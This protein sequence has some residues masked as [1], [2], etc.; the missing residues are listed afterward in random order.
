MSHL[1]STWALESELGSEQLIVFDA[2]WHLPVPS[3]AVRDARAEYL[4]HH[5]P[6]ALFADIDALSDQETS[7]PHMLSSPSQFEAQMR[8]LGLSRRSQVVVYDSHGLFSAPRLWWMLGTYGHG[9]VRILD[10]GLPKW[11][12]EGRP[13][14]SGQVT[15]KQ[16]DFKARFIAGRVASLDGARSAALVLDA[17]SAQRFQ[18]LAPEPRPTVPSGHMPNARNLPF[19]SVVR[20]GR[21]RPR[22]ELEAIF[23]RVGVRGGGPLVT[24]CGSGVT[25]AII[26]LALAEVG[27]SLNTLYDG[28]WT[29]FAQRCPSEVVT[30]E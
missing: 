13:V 12:D 11:L 7:L 22:E 26:S 5:I 23:A 17:R 27:H 16:G 8:A 20:D 29:E 28:S 6:G 25:A 24:S 21:L 9:Q 14:E 3:G 18:G 30:G 15:R 10:G 4:D 2:S 19:D 1:I